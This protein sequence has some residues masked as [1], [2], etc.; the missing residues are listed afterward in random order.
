MLE[1]NLGVRLFH[2][3]TRKLTLTEAGEQF[4]QSIG[5]NLDALQAA[6]AGV[7]ADHGEPGGILKV[8]MAP[9][10]GMTHLMPV[11]P[12]FLARYPRIRAEWH[13]ENRQVDLVAEG[14]DAAIGGGFE[15]APG[16]VSRPLAPAHIIAVASPEYMKRHPHPT[17]PTDLAGFDAIVMRSTRTGRIRQWV[18]RD[19][20]GAEMQAPLQETFVVNDPAA[21][22]EAAVLGLGV[23]LIAVPDV[24]RDLESGE[25]VRLLPR[26]YADAGAI[27]VYYANRTL[28]PAKTRVFIDYLTEEF[29]R[30]RLA[31]RLAGSLG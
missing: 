21:M 25:L 24:L 14:Y 30:T 8:S 2:R 1:R 9:T 23:T 29:K 22:R 7:S 27:S 20:S 13:F 28:L 4:L 19:V 5:G 18:M 15:L 31:E 3:S 16:M 12:E 11:L 6:I 17:V 10:F 26:W